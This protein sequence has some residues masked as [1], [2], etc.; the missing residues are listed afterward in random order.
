MADYGPSGRSAESP[1]P[2]EAIGGLVHRIAE[3]LVDEPEHVVINQSDESD[4]TVFQLRVDRKDVGRVIGKKGATVKA[5][6]TVVAAAGQKI[7]RRLTV[8]V[9]D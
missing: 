7:G 4:G 3:M 5:I 1:S 2:S 9:L 6:R 8:E